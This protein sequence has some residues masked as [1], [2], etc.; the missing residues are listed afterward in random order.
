MIVAS[1]HCSHVYS[2]S[3]GSLDRRQYLTDSLGLTHEIVTLQE[4]NL[5]AVML[6]LLLL[7]GP[8]VTFARV[9]PGDNSA[10]F[11]RQLLSIVNGKLCKTVFEGSGNTAKCAGALPIPACCYEDLGTCSTND[12]GAGGSCYA[13]KG[14]LAGCCPA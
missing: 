13:S 8:A 5:L 12:N 9:T 1:R 7:T 14:G 2:H 10:A 4:S 6:G 11:T 3:D